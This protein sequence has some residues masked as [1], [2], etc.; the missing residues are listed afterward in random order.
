M[1][2]NL[3]EGQ[4]YTGTKGNGQV[5]RDLSNLVGLIIQNKISVK[6]AQVTEYNTITF[7]ITDD[8]LK[9]LKVIAKC[10]N[11]SVQ[12]LLRLGMEQLNLVIQ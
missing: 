3:T 11:I 1:K 4:V 10:N 8:E 9:Q 7:R 5:Q 2:I 12:K 6:K